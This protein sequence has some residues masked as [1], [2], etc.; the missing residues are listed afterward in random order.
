MRAA[1]AVVVG[2][3]P[4]T[5]A[6]RWLTRISRSSVVEEHEAHRGLAENRLRGGEVGLDLRSVATSTTMHSAPLPSGSLGMT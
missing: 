3:P 2:G 5:V 1:A 4:K 6:N